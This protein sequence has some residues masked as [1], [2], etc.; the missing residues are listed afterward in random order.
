MS[1]PDPR[2]LHF[3]QTVLFSA[4]MGMAIP[5]VFQHL[6]V[7]FQ[8]RASTVGWIAAVFGGVQVAV[9]LPLGRW[10]DERGERGAL[11]V[12]WGLTALAGVSLF[13]AGSTLALAGAFTLYGLAIGIF[14][15]PA[16]TLAARL[17][18]PGE[19]ARAMTVFMV[20]TGIG[21]T[22][23]PLLGGVADLV[24]FEWALL[25]LAPLGLLGGVLALGQRTGGRGLSETV[26]PEADP[27]GLGLGFA[28]AFYL[29]FLLGTGDAFIP[30]LLA[31]TGVAAFGVGMF[32]AGREG[33]NL[34][35]RLVTARAVADRTAPGF[36]ALGALAG[37]VGLVLFPRADTVFA[38]A[39]SASLMGVGVG[40][41]APAS[42]TLTARGTR[43]ADA[44]RSMG[45]WGA[46]LGVGMLVGPALLGPVGEAFGLA[47]V[48]DGTAL[49]SLA[50]AG[51]SGVRQVRVRAETRA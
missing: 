23:G 24:G 7:T 4:A 2:R 45:R 8:A 9:R 17:A 14:W 3:A 6:E 12:S 28:S 43:P 27:V 31:A 51:L 21:F 30:V 13:Q 19:V 20:A 25:S 38:L 11:V 33:V 36:L 32:I 5:L 44:G 10:V 48:F 40:L 50:M 35:A 29:G 18:Q 39:A 46:I 42:L 15:V 22:A 41:V 49:L 26:G 47:W 1:R 37:A 34:L 16:N